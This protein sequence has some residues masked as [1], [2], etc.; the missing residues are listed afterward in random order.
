MHTTTESS[1]TSHLRSVRDLLAELDNMK[2]KGIG[3]RDRLEFILDGG[4]TLV[5]VFNI[6]DAFDLEARAMNRRL[7][8]LGDIK[9]TLRQGQQQLRGAPVQEEMKEAAGRLLGHLDKFLEDALTRER[10]SEIEMLSQIWSWGPDISHIFPGLTSGRPKPKP[11]EI[12]AE[13]QEF[14]QKKAALYDEVREEFE[15]HP[16]HEPVP[17]WQDCPVPVP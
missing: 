12:P 5:D 15:A 3:P 17:G 9:S 11:L 7:E 8:S 14:T 6:E 4:A 10:K 13:I 1:S 16:H 2:N